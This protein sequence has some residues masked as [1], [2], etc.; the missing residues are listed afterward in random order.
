MGNRNWVF[1]AKT[2]KNELLPLFRMST[3]PITRHVKIINKANVYDKEFNEYFR[4][5]KL[6]KS[7][8]G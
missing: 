8:K 2:D 3:I 5:R 7:Y 1:A 4:K 6:G